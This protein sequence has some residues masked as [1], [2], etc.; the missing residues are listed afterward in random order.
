[1]R[2]MG[3]GLLAA[4]CVAGGA[5][6]QTPPKLV[7]AYADHLGAMC[8]PRAPGAPPVSVALQMTDLN[9]DGRLDW[10]VDASR[11]PCPSRPKAVDAAGPP[12]TVFL[13]NE[14]GEAFPAFQR[15]AFGARL[16]RTPEGEMALW[17]T[18]GGSDCGDGGPETRCERRLIWLPEPKRLE[19]QSPRAGSSRP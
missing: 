13:A 2:A 6:A 14:A 18:L 10:I 4:L 12:V 17:I 16:Q 5:L 9:A 1:M 19:L 15:L 11:Y 3:A 8:G 7:S